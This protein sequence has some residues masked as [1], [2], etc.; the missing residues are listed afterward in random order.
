MQLPE[1][2]MNVVWKEAQFE[3]QMEG[4]IRKLRALVLLVELF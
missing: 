4:L 3:R 2:M 1:Q